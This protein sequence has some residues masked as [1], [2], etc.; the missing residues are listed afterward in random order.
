MRV[1]RVWKWMFLFCSASLLVLPSSASDYSYARIVR[2]S[3]VEGEVQVSRPHQDQWDVGALNMPIEQGFVIATQ[4]GRAEVEF[5]DGTAARLSSNTVLQF[6]ELA[7][8]NGG[9]ITRLTLTQG[10]ASFATQSGKADQFTVTTPR[11]DV[12]IPPHTSVRVDVSG[13]SSVS[14]FHGKVNLNSFEGTREV[15]SG[16]TAAFSNALGTVSISPNAAEDEWDRWVDSRQGAL[17]SG[18][19]EAQQYA[20]APVSY[21]MADLSTYGSWDYLPGYGYGWQPFGLAAGWA[22]FTAGGWGMYPGLG[23]TW[24]SS[25]P[26]GWLPYHF[27]N[28]GFDPTFGWLWF[29][30]YFNYW[31]AAP[32]QWYG[33][34]RRIGWSPIRRLT[35]PERGSVNGHLAPVGRFA[36]MP[37]VVQQTGQLGGEGTIRVLSPGNLKGSIH[38][39]ALPPLPDGKAPKLNGPVS[40]QS[41]A[42]GVPK[43]GQYRGAPSVVVPT[44][45]GLAYIHSGVSYDPAQNRFVAGTGA[46]PGQ[47]IAPVTM[48]GASRVTR[49]PML[50]LLGFEPGGTHA[51]GNAGG[52]RFHTE[53]SPLGGGRSLFPG[54]GS[55]GGFIHSGI[56][57]PYGGGRGTMGGGYGGSIGG[58]RMGGVSSGGGSSGGG[59]GGGGGKP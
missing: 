28:W 23:W 33:N 44:L 22:P 51:P 53:P 11:L 7:L 58:G 47:R 31:C 9:R 40:A 15:K 32:V 12:A 57:N 18:A 24:L 45:P 1:S 42:G 30:G 35:T 8:S 27:G 55:N 29:P 6:T 36:P 21:G 3:Y 46:L 34:G 54:S 13:T 52:P 17:T 16:E 20:D 14:V 59:H 4:E 37:V 19:A 10:T 56:G 48:N 49:A 2:L 38:P 39:L 41:F 50:P 5:E 26:W 43:G 25:E